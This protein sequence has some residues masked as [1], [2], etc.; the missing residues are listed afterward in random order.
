MDG[1]RIISTGHY[2]PDRVVTND[3]LSKI[4]D[5]SDEWITERTGIK[6]RHFCNDDEGNVSMAVKAA[7]VALEK[8]DIDISEIGCL[9]VSTFSGDYLVPSAACQVQEKLGM[10][11]DAICFDLNA[12][13][14]GFV[15]GMETIRGLLLQ[16]DKKY[17]LLI[18]SECISRRLDMQDR[19]TCILF[20]D[21]AGAVLFTLDAEKSY[22]SVFG[23]HGD[24]EV[25][26]VPN[27]ANEPGRVH[28]A[29]Q[30]TYKFAVSTVPKLIKKVVLKAGIEF[31]DIDAYICHQANAR[32]LDAVAKHLKQPREKFFFDL[33]EYGNTSAASVAIALSD[34]IDKGFVK[35]GQKILLCGFG[36]GKTWGAIIIDL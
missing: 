27:D 17:G 13:C 6:R 1:L 26:N 21:G 19:G 12:A 3:D 31:E 11:D 29:G 23:C 36:A 10:S 20:G 24:L 15:F 8:I 7:T 34:A 9:V 35:P 5:T 4:V 33:D 16:S 22:T 14:S 18:G 32:I 2:A 25:I 28:M 30:A